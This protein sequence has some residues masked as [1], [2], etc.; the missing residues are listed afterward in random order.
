MIVQACR[1]GD[2]SLFRRCAKRGVRVSTAH[3]LCTAAVHGNLD[4]VR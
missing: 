3:P 2:V 1:V 4:A